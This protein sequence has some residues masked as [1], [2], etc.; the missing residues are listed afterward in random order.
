MKG[1]VLLHLRTWKIGL[2]AVA[3]GLVLTEFL[4]LSHCNYFGT[5]FGVTLA[6]GATMFTLGILWREHDREIRR[7]ATEEAQSKFLAAAETS[8]DAFVIFDAVRD[9]TG[10]VIDFRFQYVNANFERMMGKPRSQLLG[11]LRSTI[12]SVPTRSGLFKRLCTVVTTG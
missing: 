12:T 1:Q 5:V 8:M 9:Q 10:E 11:Q 2:A 6:M 3:L 7:R 4:R